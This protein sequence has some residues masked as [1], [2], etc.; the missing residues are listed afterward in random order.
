MVAYDFTVVPCPIECDKMLRKDVTDHLEGECLN[1]DYECK[2]CQEKGTYG[3]ITQIH[4]ALCGKKL[5]FCP[6]I[7]CSLTM[8]RSLI[9][10]HSGNIKEVLQDRKWITC[11][12]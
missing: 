2:Y 10:L 6:N 11:S 7:E 5:L 9:I 4:D 8:E 12:R 3:N 1:R